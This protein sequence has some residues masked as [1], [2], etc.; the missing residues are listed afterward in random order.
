MTVHGVRA[1]V[2]SDL[3]AVDAIR[4]ADSDPV[5]RDLH[6]DLR[7]H[8][9]AGQPAEEVLRNVGA[10]AAYLQQ[11]RLRPTVDRRR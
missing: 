5:Q 2:L 6:G 4:N 3:P 10:C 9:D 7:T 1:A 11:S 8:D